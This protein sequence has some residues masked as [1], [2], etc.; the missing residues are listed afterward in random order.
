M[1]KKIGAQIL[2]ESLLKENVEIVFGLPGGQVLPI[3][4]AIYGS[5]LNFILTRHEQAASHMADG[6]A[7]ST[8]KPGVCIVTS[9]PG[10]TNIVTGLASAYMDSV[11]MV[12]VSGQV[13][14]SVIGQDAFQ[15]V[16]IIG[17]TR[18]VTKHNFLVKNVRD[19]ARTIK[20]AFYIA[21]TGRPGPVLIDIPI[22]VQRGACEF[23]YPDKVEIRSYKPNYSGHIEQI[24]KAAEVINKSKRPVFY[25]G[26]GVVVSNA[27]NEI[28]ELSKKADIPVTN[29]L[30][31][32]G[33]YPCDTNLSL[34]MLGMYGT[35]CANK[36]MQSAD[37]IIAVGARFDDR[38]TGKVC[39]F[40]RNAKIIHVDIDSTAIS[41]IVDVDI[42]VVGD[43]KT[44]LKEIICLVDKKD[45]KD[46]IKTVDSWKEK[47]PLFYE[48]NDDKLHPQYVIEKISELT[49]GEAI[50]TTD[51]GQHQMWSAQYYKAKYSRL[52]LSSGGLGTMGFGYPAAIGAKFGN[53]NKEVIAVTGDGSFQMN[54]QEMAVAVLNE[55]DVKVVILN[56][57]YLGNVR[58]WQEMFYG[59]RYSHSCLAKRKKCFKWCNTPNRHSCPVYVP[60]FVRWA[61]S[62]GVLGI[63]VAKKKDVELALKKML[64]T[65]SSVV[66][67]VWVEIE[68]NIFPMVP[69]GASLDEMITRMNG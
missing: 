43:A 40:A 17:I 55:V 1:K 59:R 52:F 31:A 47:Y 39:D 13:A 46:W 34:G 69:S 63:R 19:L 29:T 12:A 21:T 38:C 36:A 4:D 24:N 56:N 53:P 65:K 28:L 25:I 10:A 7:R 61:E 54:M 22:D 6:Y 58:Q 50:I 66:I 51:V 60:D 57:Q 42:P 45:R 18:P 32:I 30:L 23:I 48:K 33:V 15:E 64:E 11:P 2:I 41:K 16:D 5:R 68:E 62:Y 67:D 9:G 37:V 20:E 44:V 26:A 27:E 49:K 14:T 3:F 35:Y 8:G